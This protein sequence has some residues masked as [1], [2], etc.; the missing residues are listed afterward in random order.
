MWK[1]IQNTEFQGKD[2]EN[3]SMEKDWLIP[4]QAHGSSSPQG[5]RSNPKALEPWA[6]R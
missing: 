4:I 1:M 5:K 2:T 3:K 6:T